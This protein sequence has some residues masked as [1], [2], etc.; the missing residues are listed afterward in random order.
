MFTRTPVAFGVALACAAGALPAAAQTVERVEI[1]GSAIKRIDAE[2]ALPVQV[3]TRE[4]IERTGAVNVE[5]LM[6]TVSAMVSSGA[7]MASTASGATTGGISSVSLRG[8]TSL[9]TLVLVNGRRLSPYGIGFTNDSVSVDVNSIPVAA[10]E[11]VEVLKDGA[12]ALYG[13]DAIAGVVNFILRKDY[14]GAELGLSV[15]AT[16]Q[17]GAGVKR[18]NG[19]WGTGDL[20][21]D[22]Y[23]LMAMASYQKENALFGRDRDFARVGY[24]A[25]ANN[26]TTSGNT[27]PAN[28]AAADGSFGSVNPTAA[29][30]CVLPYSFIDPLKSPDSCRF[31]PAPLITLLPATERASLFLAGR[32]RLGADLEGYAELSYNRNSARTVVQPVPIS[33]QFTLPA[34][35]PLYDLDPY[36]VPGGI[37]T[38]TILL[39]SSSPYYPTAFVTGLTGG[40]TPDLL[41]RYR[42]AVNGNRD[43]TD[44]AVSPRVVAGVRGSAAGWDFDSA[45]LY[46]G[47]QVR[48]RAN[49]GWP[50]L[51]KLMPLLNS[52]RV[53]F[54]GPNTPDVEAEI[55][56][57][58]FNGDTFKVETALTSLTARGS[59]DLMDLPGGTASFAV[60]AEARQ[61]KYRFSPST[62]L[63]QGDIAGYGGNFAFVDRSR[64]VG[65]VYGEVT[66][67]LAKGLEADVAV[68][69]DRYQGVGNSTTPKASLRWQPVEQLVVRGAIGRGFRAPSLA[70]LFAP[71]TTGVTPQGLTDPLRCPTTND[72]IKDCQTQFPTANG[73][74]DQLRPEKSRN[75]N[76]GI[77]LEPT[78]G[79]SM[80]VDAFQIRLTDTIAN[81]IPA[82]VI[83]ADQ[84]KY[85]VYVRRGAVDP[86][87]PTLPGAINTIDLH[88]LNTGESRLSGFDFDFRWRLPAAEAG[89]FT[90]GLAGTYFSKFDAQNPDGSFTGTVDQVNPNTGGVIPR[91]KSYQSV[92]WALG[93][94]DATLSVNWQKHYWDFNGSLEDPTDP[95]YKPRRVSD[96]TTVDAQVGWRPM[97]DLR[98]VLGVKNLL[99]QDPPYT[100]AGGQLSFQSG[101][102]QQYGDPRGRFVYVN[103]N[104]AFK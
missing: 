49:D 90:L 62:A 72:P 85:G 50:V 6:Q 74:N 53:N 70:D 37:S 13:S 82:A 76:L 69:Y 64:T 91:L 24:D 67:P 3:L 75:I 36:R 55:R 8:L 27:F 63:E 96:Y 28:I 77:V 21:S 95:A 32:V 104:W 10:I 66:L 7:N 20:A 38:S 87:F 34:N 97:K 35:N 47:S 68:R 9:R 33:D 4:E 29:S 19:A 52:G 42:A 16:T 73:G 5:Q 48:E 94:V 14:R 80:A 31:D 57:T 59:R 92:N 79:L 17:G 89:V 2:T 86:A 51:T 98:L 101:Y 83:L 12:S 88:N 1:T 84:A 100:N 18:I 45:L 93:A 102:D 58:N 43:I 65:A 46:S 26:D 25:A 30:G 39:N 60:G 23:Q 54:F 81:G 15:G 44:I 40:A 61:E 41:V 99:D 78:K 22:G 56:A 11:R 71:T 103:L